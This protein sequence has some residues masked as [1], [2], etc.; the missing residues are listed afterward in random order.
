MV[1]V[2]RLE[3]GET[4]VADITESSILTDGKTLAKNVIGIQVTMTDNKSFGIGFAPVFMFA[5]DSTIE[6]E[7]DK[8]VFT[9][10]PD[11]QVLNQYN[12]IFGTGII[13]PEKGIL[14]PSV[15]TAKIV[16][17]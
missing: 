14:R 5:K 3:S 15:N 6:I 16:D 7:A 9:A 11:D 8:I 10:N 1:K 12:K 13:I 17:V 2:I 4:I